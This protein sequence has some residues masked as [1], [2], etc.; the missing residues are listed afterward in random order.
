MTKANSALT[1]GQRVEAKKYYKQVTKDSKIEKGDVDYKLVN[2]FMLKKPKQC[3]E[4]LSMMTPDALN[5]FALRISNLSPVYIEKINKEDVLFD[6]SLKVLNLAIAENKGAGGGFD[7]AK[8]LFETLD[9]GWQAFLVPD[10]ESGLN[11]ELS[12]CLA[13]VQ[14][15]IQKDPGKNI[16]TEQLVKDANRV[17]FFREYIMSGDKGKLVTFHDPELAEALE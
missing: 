7:T 14:K 8:A 16:K 2:A 11:T 5:A 10:N 4:M 13:Y 12:K 15:E 1:W 9:K 6:L 17:A 3:K